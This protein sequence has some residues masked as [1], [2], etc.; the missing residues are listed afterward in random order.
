LVAF[1]TETV[2]GLGADATNAAAVRKIFSAKG[3]P[4]TNPLICHVPD[5]QVA[6]RYAATWPREAERLTER[7][8]PGPLTIVLPKTRDIVAEATAGRETV[9]LRAPDHELTLQLLRIVDLPI[10]GPSAN[11]SS[12]V[13]PTTADHVRE[14]LGDE[15]DMILEG[16][17]CAVGI[18]ST[19]LDLSGERPTILR[20]GGV[21]RE[22]IEAVIG[23]IE[24]T[25]MI[26]EVTKPAIAPGQHP[27]HYAPRTPAFRFDDSDRGSLNLLGA[28][29]IELTSDASEYARTFYARLRD[30]DRQHL[31]AIFIEMPPDLPQWIAV[32]DR[33]TRATK[34][35]KP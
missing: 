30:L 2:Y 11:K 27:I 32:R 20:P 15:V 9:A 29:L 31:S 34:P 19:V 1:P 10:G 23:S 3:R 4:A 7:F 12:H 21:S 16:G 35:L 5:A 18:E 22:Q 17:A 8:W 28:G 14:E 26:T 13:S 6:K 33:I 24:M 25:N